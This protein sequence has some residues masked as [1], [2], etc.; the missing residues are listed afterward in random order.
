M[1]SHGKPIKEFKR[2]LSHLTMALNQ[3]DLATIASIEL[4]W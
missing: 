1:Y 4:S 3:A 2:L